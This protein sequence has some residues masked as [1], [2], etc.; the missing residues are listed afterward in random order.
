MFITFEGIDGCGKST[1]LELLG[2]FLEEEGRRVAVFRE[3]GGPELSEKIRSLLLDHDLPIDPVSELLLFSAARSQLVTEKVKPLLEEGTWVMLDRFYDSTTAYQGYGRG[4]LPMEEIT[5]INR[6]AS[7]RCTP[8]ITFYLSISLK[9]ARKRTEGEAR[10]RM[11][12]SDDDFYQRVIEGFEEL[13]RRE[14]RIVKLDA[15]EEPA[16]IH[17]RIRRHLDRRA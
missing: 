16:R 5:Q 11:E 17:R 14:K 4:S 10:D 8:D 3:P 15:R 13:A 6:I 7:H 12:Q 2:E 1:Q 9:E